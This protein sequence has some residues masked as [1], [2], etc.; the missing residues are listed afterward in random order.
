[1]SVNCPIDF[2]WVNIPAGDF[3][4]GE[5][6]Q[7]KYLPA[8]DIMLHPVTV[9]QYLVFC[10]TSG[11][12]FPE[13]PHRGL[14][15]DH[16]IVNVSWED[17]AS[18]ASWAGLSLPTE[19]EWEKAARGTDGR[20]YPWGNQWNPEHCCHACWDTCAVGQHPEGASPFGVLDMAGNVWEWC[21][22]W[23]Q[24]NFTRVQRGGSWRTSFP[25]L[26]RTTYR[27]RSYPT[28]KNCDFGFR[29]VRRSSGAGNNT[30]PSAD[31]SA[32]LSAPRNQLSLCSFLN[33]P[34]FTECTN[35]ADGATMV[36]VPEGLFTMGSNEQHGW[37]TGYP[38]HE[39]YVEGFWIY[40]HVVTVRQ[41]R[42][43]CMTTANAFD[44]TAREPE[45]GWR[46]DHPMV[47][48]RWREAKA[49]AI[50]AGAALPTEEEWEKAA[51]GT[52]GRKFPWG[53]QWD[54]RKC[55]SKRVSAEHT[56]PVGRYAA[57][58]S[59]YG[60]LDMAGNVWEWCDSV[61]EDSR[62]LALPKKYKRSGSDLRV[63]R[64]GSW[65]NG[66]SVFFLSTCRN[67]LDS[68]RENNTVGFR[69]VLRRSEP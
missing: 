46:D 57:G 7:T 15:W 35:T 37:D 66:D 39:V 24:V 65:A 16:P 21:D 11:R 68:A 26:F 50:W 63:L 62:M 58:A 32:V 38:Q 51:R 49:Y 28:R 67:S 4:Y 59:P 61:H 14:Y 1:M 12:A 25:H 40:K 5:S 56:C 44:W 69:C 33:I 30:P 55:C 19:E 13:Y 47:N 48:V 8:Y 42:Q 23:Y 41:F 27:S 9:E 18:F 45:W 10:A 54:S 31:I 20:E 17:A 53:N 43:F 36:W 6:Q 60:A 64:G 34:R 29:C 22:S 2:T 52:D 3:L